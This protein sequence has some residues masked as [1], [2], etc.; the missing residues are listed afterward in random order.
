VTDGRRYF[1]GVLHGHEVSVRQ[2]QGTMHGDAAGVWWLVECDCTHLH[3]LRVTRE[4][5]ESEGRYHLQVVDEAA[6]AVRE[7]LPKVR[8]RQ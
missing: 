2:V 5:A 6:P 7:W 8:G 3:I 4:D 1:V